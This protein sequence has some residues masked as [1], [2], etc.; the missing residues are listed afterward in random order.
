M[1][2]KDDAEKIFSRLTGWMDGAESMD[3]EQLREVRRMM[4]DNVEVSERQFLS[5]LK[6]L[7][8]GLGQ[9]EELAEPIAGLLAKAQERGLDAVALADKTGLSIVLVTKLDRRL[10]VFKSIPN[11]LFETLASVLQSTLTAVMD[12]LRQ[13]QAIAM[14]ARFRTDESPRLPEQ[15][16]FFDAVRTDKSISEDRRAALLALEESQES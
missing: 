16:G 2:D 6:E 9:P 5:V 8:A 4:G 14:G 7:K 11:K 3:L 12:Y 13:P 10:L 15:Q 1:S